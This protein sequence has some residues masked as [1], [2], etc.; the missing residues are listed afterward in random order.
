VVRVGPFEGV[1]DAPPKSGLPAPVRLL[2]RPMPLMVLALVPNGPP[3]RLRL[4]GA[5]HDIARSDGPERIEP[6]LPWRRIRRHRR[7]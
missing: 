1:P 6:E 4:E 5:V 7:S 2:K 3:L